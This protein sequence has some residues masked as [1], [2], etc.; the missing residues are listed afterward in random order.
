VY[1][2]VSDGG[3]LQQSVWVPSADGST[4]WVRFENLD[5]GISGAPSVAAWNGS[6]EDIFVRG[7]DNALWHL[8]WQESVGWSQ[9]ESLGGILVS[10]PLVVS[11]QENWLDIFVLGGGNS[12]CWRGYHATWLEWIC[13]QGNLTFESI[14]S[15]VVLGSKRVDAVGLASDDHVYHKS[16]VDSSWSTN[17]DD[18]GGPLNGA[19]VVTSSAPNIGNIFGIGMDNALYVGNWDSS[20]F[21]WQGS[22]VWSSLGGDF[23]PLP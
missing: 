3:N 13:I 15:A 17:W 5:G 8:Y 20:A 12:F 4:K 22:N 21:S 1:G 23:I 9:W 14:P 6:R 11:S 10:T 16:L 2:L 18:L 19:P 7:N